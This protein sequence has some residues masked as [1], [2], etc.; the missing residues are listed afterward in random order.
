MLADRFLRMRLVSTQHVTSRDVSYEFMNRQMVWHAFTVSSAFFFLPIADFVSY[1]QEFLLFALP[2]VN[3]RALGRKIMHVSSRFS[4]AS[5]VPSSIR[6]AFDMSAGTSTQSP[7]RRRG[8]YW[9]LP[10]DQCA[11]CYQDSTTDLSDPATALSSLASPVYTS[12]NVDSPPGTTE[13]AE[14]EPPPYPLNTP[15]ITDC[16]HTYCYVCVTNRMT[17]IAYDASGVGP[18]G[19]RWECLRCGQGVVRIDRVENL[20]DGCESEYGSEDTMSF[21]FGSED[22]DFTDMSGSLGED[23]ESVESD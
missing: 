5:M 3:T 7:T 15:Y 16:G 18:G 19:A 12:N 14:E 8:K 17:H 21:E 11:I 4:V 10:L 1:M 13:G 23:S 20:V 22:V 2:M 9:S 6:E